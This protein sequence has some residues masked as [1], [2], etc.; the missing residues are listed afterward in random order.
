MHLIDISGAIA[1]HRHTNSLALT[2]GIDGLEFVNTS[3][4]S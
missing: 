1:C 4:V 2:A 3:P